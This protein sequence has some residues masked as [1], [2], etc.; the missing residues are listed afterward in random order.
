MLK[1]AAILAIVSVLAFA[2]VS[3]AAFGD[4]KVVVDGRVAVSA[5]L[6]DRGDASVLKYD[7]APVVRWLEL[8][9]YWAGSEIG[10]TFGEESKETLIESV[11]V[12]AIFDVYKYEHAS[13][14]VKNLKLGIGLFGK[15]DFMME[16][17]QGGLTASGYFF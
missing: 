11:F 15:Y 12:S 10:L 7:V 9:K 2:G 5:F 4:A 1:L 6:A 17:Y 13:P 16:D 14:V 8:P 3:Q